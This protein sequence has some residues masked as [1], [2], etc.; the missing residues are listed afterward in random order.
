MASKLSAH[1]PAT[2]FPSGHGNWR[3][4]KLLG[5]TLC[6]RKFSTGKFFGASIHGILAHS[7][8]RKSIWK[9]GTIFFEPDLVARSGV[10]ATKCDP[11]ARMRGVKKKCIFHNFRNRSLVVGVGVLEVLLAMPERNHFFREVFPTLCVAQEQEE[12]WSL[13]EVSPASPKSWPPQSFH[14]TLCYT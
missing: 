7:E 14:C 2:F 12:L 10:S 9:G 1:E 3:K 5:K 4:S 13:L 8:F 6:T 11:L